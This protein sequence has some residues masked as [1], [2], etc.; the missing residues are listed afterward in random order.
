MKSRNKKGMLAAVLAAGLVLAPLPGL[1]GGSAA[2][3]AKPAAA[4]IGK[5]A[6]QVYVDGRK[7]ALSPPPVTLSGTTLVPMRAIFKAL[8]A[9]VTWEPSTK[10]IIGIKDGMSV[11]LQLGSKKAVKNGK[12]VLLAVPAQQL[13][14]TTMVPLRFV[15]ETLGAE[16][17]VDAASHAIRITSEEALEQQEIDKL[18]EEQRRQQQDDDKEKLS[19]RQIVDENDAKVVM[20]T[21][22]T[23]QGS[24]VIIG[25]DRILTNFH[26]VQ[27]AASA[28]VTL[29]DGTTADVKGIVGYDKD[30]D[31]AVLQT[32]K[33]LGVDP[34]KI[35]ESEL[36]GK[37]DHVVA[38]GSPLGIQNTVSEG[39]VS[40]IQSDGGAQ[41]FQISVPID[42]G[43]SGGGLFNDDGELIGLTSSGVDDTHADLNFAVSAESI[44]LLLQDIASNPPSSVAFLPSD[45]PSTLAG[46]TNDEI[47]AFMDKEYSTIE[48]SEGTAKLS[49]FQVTRDDQGWV[50]ITAVID[51]AFYMVYGHK[52]SDDLRYWAIDAGVELHKLLPDNVIQLNVYYDQTFSFQPRGFGPGEVT[53]NGDGTWRIRYPVIQVQGKEKFNVQVRD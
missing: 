43:S 48:T 26:V 53:A 45:K 50:V 8:Q 33:P 41:T 15:S 24:G 2:A 13:N 12:A 19:V 52:A 29:E 32:K 47:K 5:T 51:P 38:I 3:A 40:N 9:D 46:A 28:T 44:Q 49:D 36:V 39:I 30:S 7:L 18:A 35:G 11:T 17:A 34:V 10:T 6:Y 22:D 27:D 20:I 25:S 42:H 14:G 37:G 4:A 23:A 16:V 31:L 1:T 21:T